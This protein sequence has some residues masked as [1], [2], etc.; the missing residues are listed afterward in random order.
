MAASRVL[1]KGTWACICGSHGRTGDVTEEHIPGYTGWGTG[2]LLQYQ[3]HDQLQFCPV[4]VP[5]YILAQPRV[6]G[7]PGPEW[8]AG[9][10][11]RLVGDQLPEQ[12]VSG[13]LL[14]PPSTSCCGVL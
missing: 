9:W 6:L 8:G 12:R 10:R 2:R 4:Q 7:R 1:L 11:S 5:P 3:M 13:N 14:P